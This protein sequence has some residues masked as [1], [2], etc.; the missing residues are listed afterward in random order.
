MSLQPSCQPLAG[1]TDGS[2]T[3]LAVR[4][5]KGVTLSQSKR[6][7]IVGGIGAG[8]STL[9]RILGERLGLEVFHLDRMWWQGGGYR[10]VGA[11]TVAAHTMDDQAVRR[12]QEELAA[13]DSWIIDGARADMSVRL[14]RADT[15]IFLDLPRRT[16]MWRI[17]KRTGRPRA[18][19]PPDVE[20]SW[21]WMVLLLRWVWSYPGDKRPGIVANIEEHTPHAKVIHCQCKA[22]VRRLVETV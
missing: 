3:M 11:K 2:S 20:E 22:N 1:D 8:K 12:L 15:V 7:A 5:I 13:R 17:I 21:R 9:A 19:Y 14:A 10:I 18:D 16:C 4:D 6:L